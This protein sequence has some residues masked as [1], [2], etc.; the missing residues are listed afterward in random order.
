VAIVVDGIALPHLISLHLGI[1]PVKV[2][3]NISKIN[4][5]KR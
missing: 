4:V 5:N 2:I 1:I 3:D